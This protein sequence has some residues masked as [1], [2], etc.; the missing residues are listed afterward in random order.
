MQDMSEAEQDEVLH[1]G[2]LGH[3][4]LAAGGLCYV[5]PIFYGYDG[6]T[7][8]FHSH[9]GL[10]DDF[11]DETKEACFVVSS[12][13]SPDDWNS[14]QVFGPVEKCSIM[15]DIR[16]AEAALADVPLPP[17]FGLMPSGKPK[18]SGEKMY[19]WM[20]TPKRMSGKK[21]AHVPQA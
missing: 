13:I 9:P 15:E 10:K 4:G 2:R 18:R 6:D 3:L 17:E 1:D 8:Y 7:F 20:L 12:V 14:V 16:N 11:I 19:F 5:V 21:S